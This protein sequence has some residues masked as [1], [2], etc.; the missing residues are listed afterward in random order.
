MHCNVIQ[1]FFQKWLFFTMIVCSGNLNYNQHPLSAAVGNKISEYQTKSDFHVSILNANCHTRQREK[2]KAKLGIVG[3]EMVFRLASITL[4]FGSLLCTH[5]LRGKY[6][7][8]N[9]DWWQWA[10]P[11]LA[12]EGFKSPR[13]QANNRASSLLVNCQQVNQSK[14]LEEMR[15]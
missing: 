11:S 1:W 8:A 12:A 10:H 7:T 3:R 15:Y 6:H 5:S 4:E 2:L 14:R 13:L 9:T